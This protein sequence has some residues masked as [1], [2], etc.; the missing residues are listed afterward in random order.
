M[1]TV[2]EVRVKAGYEEIHTLA[3]AKL[4]SIEE[5]VRREIEERIAKDKNALLGIIAECEEEVEV[6]VPDE[7]VNV[8]D[9]EPAEVQEAPIY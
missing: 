6:D 9:G 1:A 5:A 3:L 4:E 2:K 7:E 8:L